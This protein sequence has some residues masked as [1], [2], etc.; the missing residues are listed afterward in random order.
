MGKRRDVV[1]PP[2]RGGWT[3]CGSLWAL[4]FAGGLAISAAGARGSRSRV[5]YRFSGLTCPN[6]SPGLVDWSTANWFYPTPNEE[7]DWPTFREAV[8]LVPEDVEAS[9]YLGW[10]RG[11]MPFRRFVS[12]QEPGAGSHSWYRGNLP[13]GMPYY[14]W[15][16]SGI[17]HWWTPNGGGIDVEREDALLESLEQRLDAEQ[18]PV[19]AQVTLQELRR[20]RGERG[21]A[22]RVLSA[23]L[24]LT[25]ITEHGVHFETGRPVHFRFMRNTERAPKL[26]KHI[27]PEYGQDIEPAGRYMLHAGPS[28]TPFATWHGGEVHFRA[29]LVLEH[30]GT[31]SR[32]PGWKARLSRAFGGKKKASLS[33]ALLAAGYDGIVTVEQTPRGRY[34]SEIVQMVTP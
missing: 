33:R 3:Q 14:V 25:Q 28:F 21:S 19:T 31:S 8:D 26:P 9:G 24:G 2:P 29:P 12:Q 23:D 10:R 34:T 32:L 22:A 16:G 15:V 4:A 7:I 18:R 13:S 27:Q 20:L 30:R 5:R 1:G 6:A 17:E 11:W